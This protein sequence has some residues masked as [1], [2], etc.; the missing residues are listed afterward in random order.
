MRRIV[1]PTNPGP[2]NGPP[3]LLLGLAGLSLTLLPE[4]SEKRKPN[5]KD[6]DPKPPPIMNSIQGTRGTGSSTASAGSEGSIK[7]WDL[8]TRKEIANLPGR[9][10]VIYSVAFSPDG[11]RLAS[12]ARQ[13]VSLWSPAL[14]RELL[15]LPGH[16]GNVR[17]VALSHDGQ[18]LASASWDHTVR[19]WDAT[20]LEK[21][22]EEPA[23]GKND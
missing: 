6:S 7:V 9:A 12:G 10:G 19:I 23:A 8:S 11:Q 18:R 14:G 22:S 15:T 1:G 2:I 17:R 4:L 21:K 3:P 13:E 16:T 20:P 5:S